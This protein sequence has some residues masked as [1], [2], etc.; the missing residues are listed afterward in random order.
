MYLDK[1]NSQNSTIRKKKL[2]HLT[3]NFMREDTQMANKH[4]KRC[5]IS[6]VFREISYNHA[7]IPLNIHLE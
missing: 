5:S 7:K 4:I 6:L 3:K 1:M 2:S